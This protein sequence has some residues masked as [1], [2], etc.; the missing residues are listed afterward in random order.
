MTLN[1]NKDIKNL[2]RD[3]ARCIKGGRTSPSDKDWNKL[4]DLVGRNR[5][6]VTEEAQLVFEETFLSEIGIPMEW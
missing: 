1:E 3:C 4:F 2:A 6:Y 5:N